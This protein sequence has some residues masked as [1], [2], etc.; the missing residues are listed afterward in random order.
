MADTVSRPV[1]TPAARDTLD[2]RDIALR[3]FALLGLAF[4]AM[5]LVD[6]IYRPVFCGGRASGCDFVRNSKWAR[7]GGV[8]LPIF[9]VGFYAVMLI[10]AAVATQAAR[11]F[12]AL[13]GG[14]GLASG[15][16]FIAIQAFAIHHFCKFCIVVDTSAVASGVCALLLARDEA[17]S[18]ASRLRGPTVAF[19]LLALLAPVGYG[20]SQPPP[21][22]PANTPVIQPMPDVI[23]REQSP[24]VATVVEFVDFEC[25]FCRRQQEAIAPV[26]ASYE[27]RVRLVRRNV[28]LSFHEHAREAARAQCCAEEQGRGDRMAEALFTSED[29]TPEGCERVAQRLSLDM[30]TYR[31]CL[32][33]HRPDVLLERDANDAR[34][35]GVGGLP[36][37]WIGR[38]KFEGFTAPDALRAS[39]DRALRA[40][41]APPADASTAARSGT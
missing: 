9:G 39:I 16:A 27:G 33:S 34:A 25:P 20:L 1:A 15:L 18:L 8:P 36:T 19:A 11:R 23:L 12:L 29:L 6:Y 41:T 7:I 2:R 10:A 3:V 37:L 21:Q 26:L 30:A 24:G 14:V 38:E 13:L 5:L 31:S 32:A 4:S 35:A 17:A 28:P 40:S 22:R